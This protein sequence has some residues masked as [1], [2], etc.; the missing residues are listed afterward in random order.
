M[1]C[2]LT[3]TVILH[4]WDLGNC[5]TWWGFWKG[6]VGQVSR[7][8][9]GPCWP[10]F[11]VC[12]R[13][14]LARFPGFWKG[15]VGQVSRF[16]EGPCWPGFQVFGRAM[17]ARFPQAKTLQSFKSTL[18]GRQTFLDLFVWFKK[19]HCRIRLSFNK[20]RS[21][22]CKLGQVIINK[23]RLSCSDRV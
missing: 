20:D 5:H 15:H 7:F 13:A 19:I 6:H 17:F 18:S 3:L 10:G 14:M 2:N 4:T 12:G 11:Q 8:L 9:E 1:L 23:V 21:D 16:L 22:Y